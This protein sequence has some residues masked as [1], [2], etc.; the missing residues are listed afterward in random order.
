MTL[1]LSLLLSALVPLGLAQNR[2]AF[3]FY[4]ENDIFAGTDRYYTHGV[5]LTWISPDKIAN[6]SDPLLFIDKTRSG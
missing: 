2:G 6:R 4:L 5:K 3:S 1:G